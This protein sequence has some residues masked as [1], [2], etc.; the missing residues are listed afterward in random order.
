MNAPHPMLRNIRV[1]SITSLLAMFAAAATAQDVKHLN[2]HTE[3]VYAVAY[4]PDG[5]YLVTG[6]F[7]KTVRIWD[8]ATG[9]T[10]RTIADVDLPRLILRAKAARARRSA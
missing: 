2:G 9:Q 6:G 3:S 4:S 1:A 10:I 5:K 7:D 8:R